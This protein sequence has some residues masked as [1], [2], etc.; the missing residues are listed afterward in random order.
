MTQQV[1]PFTVEMIE[2]GKKLD[3]IDTP[4]QITSLVRY[5]IHT[6][7][8][9]KFLP[10]SPNSGWISTPQQPGTNKSGKRR[11][12]AKMRRGSRGS[13]VVAGAFRWKEVGGGFGG[14]GA[15]AGAAAGEEHDEAAGEWANLLGLRSSLGLTGLHSFFDIILATGRPKFRHRAR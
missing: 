14:A 12:T 6:S 1:K 11:R 5:C 7:G 8:I 13:F 9:P 10:I 3:L 4:P 15:G 2:K